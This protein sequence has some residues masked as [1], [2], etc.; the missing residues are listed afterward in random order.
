MVE[1]AF[2]HM[3]QWF[4]SHTAG[5]MRPFMVALTSHALILYHERVGD[6][7]VIPTL[8]MAM[9]SLW[10]TMWLPASQ[11][12]KYTD[13]ETSTGGQ[14]PAP[15]LN[16][17]IA[18]VYIWLYHQTGEVRHRDRFDAIFVGGVQQAY[19]VNGKQ[20]N[21]NYRLSIEAVRLRQLPPLH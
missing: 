4:V 1:Q 3:D 9:D 19:L 18:P 13:R 21:Q 6:S 7:R 17:L 12:F 10:D 14:E 5:W 15:D 20:F 8:T 11:A 2:G 16:L